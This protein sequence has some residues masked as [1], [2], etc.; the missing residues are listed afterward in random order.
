M[1]PRPRSPLPRR[2]R[3]RAC[4][5]LIGIVVVLAIIAYLT[6]TG[7]LAPDPK[8]QVTAAQSYVDKSKDSACAMSRGAIRADLEQMAMNNGGGGLPSPPVVR[9]KL[10]TRQCPG[11]GTLQFDRQGRVYCTEHSPA[12]DGATASVYNL[13]D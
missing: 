1:T 11:D 4:A 2:D 7:Y 9:A 5:S 13:G 3:R 6:Y 10:G 12:S 8:T